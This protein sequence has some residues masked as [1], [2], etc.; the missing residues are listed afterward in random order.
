MRLGIVGSGKIVDELLSF[1]HE[2]KAIQL[3]H[4]SGTLR[5]EEKLKTLCTKHSFQRY[6]TNY[7]DL[8]DD[9]EVD[10]IYIAVPNHLHFA[11][12]KQAIQHHKHVIVE[13]PLT[14]TYEEA[15]QLQAI[16]LQN[17]VFMWEAITNQ[18]L[19]HYQ[20]IKDSLLELGNIKIIQ[21]HFSQYSSRYDAFQKGHILP[22]FD[23]QK[24]GG[25]LMDLNVYNI[26]FVVGLFG[27]PL[28]VHYYPHIEHHIDTSGIL[29]L[30]YPDFQC[31]CIGAK[32]C[33]S[34]SISTIQGDQGCLCIDTPVSSL[35]SF[36]VIKNDGQVHKVPDTQH[37]HNMYDEFI[38]FVE[39]YQ[40]RDYQ[41]CYQML[42]HSLIVCE[43]LT[44]ARRKAGIIFPADHIL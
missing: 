41:R 27:Q 11:F 35:R 14:S 8:L 36:Q 4:I 13:K 29:I 6:S 2:I 16:A 5:S 9:Q 40:K 39:M 37:P 33:Q 21:C 32:D 23:Y 7:Q 31:V 3:I 30:E 34:P 26:H 25:A 24:S 28:D 12:A 20:H 1:I 44:K 22:V 17:H 19:P 15:L 43:I 18:Y 42:E 38:A 10:T